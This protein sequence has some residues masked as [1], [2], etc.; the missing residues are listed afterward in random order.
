MLRRLYSQI[1]KHATMLITWPGEL[2]AIL[3]YPFIGLMSLGLLG[4]FIIE[5]GTTSQAFIFIIYGVLSWNIYSNTM[6]V[7]TRGIYY[8]LWDGTLKNLFLAR[9]RVREFIFGNMLFAL[10]SIVIVI[11]L[12][13]VVSIF[14]FNFNIFS[15][16]PLIIVGV[17]GVVVEA[18]ADSLMI[19]SLLV[20]YGNKFTNL[21]WIMPGFMMV[22][23]GVYYP[24][25]ILPASVRTISNVF[26]VT[27]AINGIRALTLS[28]EIA[29]GEIMLA[30]VG[31]L[32]YLALSLYVF[33]YA[34][35]LSKKDGSLVTLTN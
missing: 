33:K 18:F 31:G 4:T 24:I 27:H 28:P 25:S 8:E 20:K 10:I 30:L 7:L 3:V 2:S 34:Y 5:G 32:I 12:M 17:L 13:T 23:A 22:L 29:L 1:Y 14:V 11:A 35:N 16:G 15:A 19:L 26:P 21:A 6:Q 9:I